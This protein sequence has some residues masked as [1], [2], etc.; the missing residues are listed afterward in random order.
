M[1]SRG[2]LQYP[3]RRRDYDSLSIDPIDR[4]TYRRWNREVVRR[5]NKV[6]ACVHQET[7]IH[8]AMRNNRHPVIKQRSYLLL[9]V[10]RYISTVKISAL[11]V[12]SSF[13]NSTETGKHVNLTR[14]LLSQHT[15]T[16]KT[17]I[18]CNY[19]L[20]L[21]YRIFVNQYRVINKINESLTGTSLHKCPKTGL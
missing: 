13:Y 21:H 20:T 17:S 10:P 18:I 8:P 12:Q 2:D 14:F 4:R 19:P 9:V 16:I 15:Y 3:D 6:R 1:G 11:L 5:D 7:S